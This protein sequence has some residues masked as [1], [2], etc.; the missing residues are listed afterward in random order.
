MMDEVKKV[1]ESVSRGEITPEEGEKLIEAIMKRSEKKSEE[2]ENE[3]DFYLGEDEVISGDLI[4][5]G[6]K[7]SIKGEIKGDAVLMY[8]D[9]EF[10][11]RV[12]GDLVV[13]SGKIRFEGGKCG[14]GSRSH[15]SEIEW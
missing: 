14:R 7:V 15:R 8:C 11:G 10:S 3:R 12:S 2:N 4:L 9:T 13:I 6:R 5:S 1:L